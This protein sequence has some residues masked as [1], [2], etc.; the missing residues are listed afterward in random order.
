MFRAGSL[1]FALL[2]VV[3]GQQVGTLTAENHPS[4]SVQQ[5]S[6]GGSCSTQ[7]RSVVLDSNWRWLH[8]VGTST[9]CYTGNTWDTSLCPDAVTCAQNCALDG[10]DYSGTYGI[11]TSGNA[12]TLKFVT[13]GP[14]SKN[15]GS[16]VYLMADQSNYQ[17]FKLK[18][19]EFTFDVDMSNLPC[20]L[21]G[22]LYFVEMDQDGGLSRFSG[23]KAGAKYGTG[24]CDTQCPHDI[25]FI[26]GEANVEG[27]A[28]SPNDVNAGSGQYG[29]C[30]VEMDVWEANSMAAAVTPHACTIQGQT[31][32]SGTQCGDGDQ[33]YDGIC[34]KD[35]CD[36]NSFRMG[37]KSFLGPGLEVDTRQK[38]TVV[39]QFVTADNTTSGRLSEIRRL[40]VQNGRV[41][42]NSKVNIPGMEAY[43]SITDDFC[44][45]QKRT[46][47]DNNSFESMG[48]LNT[49]GEA[50]DHGMVL[51]M[52]V[53]D[54][55]AV[56]MLWLDS[57]YPTDAPATQPG[58]ARGNCPTSSGQ[59]TQV[60][61][62]SPGSSVTFSNIKFGPIGSTFA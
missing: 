51:V 62:Q 29:T 44:N 53:W 1:L 36:F 20:G 3:H 31:R 55:H 40:Y 46:F 37:D 14:Y 57:N 18:N 34:D 19:Q 10:A 9:N 33:R 35:G 60:E 52:S 2:A 13:Q 24:Y 49:M 16:R 61:S 41:I 12:L 5:C 47:G 23:N 59:P 48:G 22:A 56:N 15:I 4:L 27:W 54:D 17:M 30:C 11:T 6:Q 32:C 38:M 45:A 43:D 25:K 26:N 58:I 7:S 8:Q 50:F 42:Q 28:P 21:N 39:T